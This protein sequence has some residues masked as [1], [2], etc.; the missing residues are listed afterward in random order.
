MTRR[1]AIV[2]LGVAYVVL[3]LTCVALALS[4][5]GPTLADQQ[6]MSALSAAALR[7]C[8]SDGAKCAAAK[9][10]SRAAV[11]A[12]EGIQAERQAVAEGRD[13]VGGAVALV[14]RAEIECAQFA[15][16]K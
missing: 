11:A 10:C 12:A 13:E 14:A 4:G 5:C 2:A 1:L 6:R 3:A 8:K 15:P 7:A 9:T 16:R